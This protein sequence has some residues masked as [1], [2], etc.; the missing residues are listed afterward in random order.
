MDLLTQ[1][2]SG[3][4]AAQAGARPGEAR[5]AA[6]VGAAAGLLADADALIRSDADP[7]L[8]LEFH[9]HFTHSL[10][11]VPLGA[12]VAALLLWPLLRRRLPFPRLYLLA[13]LGY[14]PAGFLDLCTSYGTHWLW[15][16]VEG[17]MALNIIAIVDPVFTLVLAF[18]LVLALLRRAPAAARVGLVVAAAYLALGA[19]QHQ[20]A[21]DTAADLAA[22]RGHAP[23]RLLVKPTIG[24]LVLWRSVY[25]AAGRYHVDGVR[26]GLG[27]ARVYPGGSVAVFSPGRDSLPV[28]AGSLQAG[29]V[30]RFARFAQ[31]YLVRHPGREGVI[32]DVRYAMLP[33][34]T[35]PL[36]G[37]ALDPERPGRHARYRVFRDLTPGER[38]RFLD[39]VLGR[40]TAPPGERPREPQGH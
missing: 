40:E 4:L 7:L 25:A 24:N 10:F 3:A 22:E 34:S 1:G 15:P 9:R 26:V 32:G 28:P 37:I 20:R 39:M 19:L 6:G 14:L 38:R 35:R 27:G 36:W 2:L 29:D 33:T 31:G 11:F 13:L 30:R 17:P 12:L 21:L 16:L 8:F 18:A 5:V 23:E